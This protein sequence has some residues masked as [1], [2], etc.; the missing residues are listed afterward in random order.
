MSAPPNDPYN[1]GPSQAA[2]GIDD[3]RTRGEHVAQPH[4]WADR[5][6][7]GS[8]RWLL[9]E[10]AAKGITIVRLEDRL[11]VSAPP[12]VFT[13]EYRELVMAMKPEIIAALTTYPCTDCGRFQFMAPTRCYWCRT[14]GPH[15]PSRSPNPLT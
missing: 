6:A 10:L 13:A 7:V 12:G 9:R 15:H 3:R 5:G 2:L 14:L 4:P 1:A 11:R 8:A